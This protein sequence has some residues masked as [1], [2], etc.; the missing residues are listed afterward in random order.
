MT[1]GDHNP[2]PSDDFRRERALLDPSLFFWSEG[3]P[4]GWPPPTDLIDRR[5]T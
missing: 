4:N 2:L 5:S 3:E 1:E